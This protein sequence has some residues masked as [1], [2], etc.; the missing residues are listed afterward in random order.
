MRDESAEGLGERVLPFVE[1][2]AE[3]TT[4]CLITMVQGNLLALTLAH[5]LIASRTGFAAGAVTSFAILVARVERPWVVSTL[6]GLVT[7][8]VD[9][10]VHPGRFG[11]FFLEAIVTGAGAALLSFVVQRGVI[12]LRRR[13]ARRRR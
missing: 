9:Y 6:L 4:A 1:N 5:W 7:T 12:G 2:V 8:V 3:A 10:L 13:R 11:P